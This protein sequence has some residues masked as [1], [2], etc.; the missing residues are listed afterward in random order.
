MEKTVRI[1]NVTTVLR[2]AGIESFIMNM[3]RNIDRTKVQFDFMVMRDEKEFYDDEIAALGGRKA[4]I[5]VTG[6]NT[7]IRIIK[8]SRELYKFLKKNPY[9]IVHIHYTTPLRALYLF[10]AKK[11]GSKVRIYHSHSAEVSG[12]SKIKLA[13]YSYYR[14]K[15]AKWATHYFA[16]SEAAARW[17]FPNSILDANK[18]KIIYNGIDI[19]RFAFDEKARDEIRQ[20]YSLNGKYVL[21]HTGRFLDQKN[22]RFI[23]EIFR[24]VKKKCP[25]AKLMLLGTG[26]LLDEIKK[27]VT[28]YNLEDDVLFMGVRS[29]VNKF[30]CAADCFLMPSLYEGLPVAAVEAECSGLP[31]IF[32]DCITSEVALTNNVTFLSLDDPIDKWS[33]AVLSFKDTVRHDCSNIV[34]DKGYSIHNGVRELEKFYL[35]SVENN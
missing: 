19:E 8:E 35:K 13:I 5:S 34:Q 28:N 14:K 18:S 10:A 24:D 1:L 6:K 32:S 22:H 9:S 17:M 15:I 31:C 26:D 7:F 20:E 4:T 25:E 33:D 16:C 12:K 21:A 27:I 29:D 3:Y 2:A 30:L 11:A 23:I